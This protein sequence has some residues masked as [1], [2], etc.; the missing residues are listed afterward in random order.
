MLRHGRWTHREP[1]GDLTDAEGAPRQHLD[2][3]AASGI[4]EGSETE[5]AARYLSSII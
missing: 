1:A 5:H 3:A 4:G 2:D